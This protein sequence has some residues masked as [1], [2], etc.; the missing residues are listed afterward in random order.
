MNPLT[1]VVIGAGAGGLTAAAHLARRGMRVTVVE[2]NEEAGGRC[3]RVV[4]EGHTFDIGPTLY[5]MPKV[6]DHEFGALG[7][8]VHERL[9][10]QRVDST[11]HLVFDD[12]HRLELT[13]DR[14][15]MRMQL[16]AMEP[17][18]FAGFERYFRQGGCHYDLAM[19]H[20][21]GRNFR[22]LAEFINPASLRVFLQVGALTRHYAGMRSF[23]R[24]PHLKAAFT[25]QDMYMGLSPFEAPA[26][27]SMMQYTELAHGVWFPQ[28]GMYT[29]VQAVQA[30]A[31][32]NG[33]QLQFG[34]PVERILAREDRAT[35]IALADGRELPADIVVANADLPYVYR[36][37]LPQDGT[38][39]RLER[40]QYSCSTINFMW[41]TDRPYPQ[42]PAHVLF[43]SDDYRANFD[44]L[45]RDRTIASN[46]SVHIHA[47]TRLD[48]ALAPRGHDTL[49]AVVPVGH[50]N[51][52]HPQNWDH[53][54]A[55][56]REA[57]LQR[58]ARVGVTD[59]DAHLK[60]ELCF[61]P[62]DWQNRFNL[63]RGATHGLS[64]RLMQMGY[65][66]PHNRHARHRNLY[67]AGASTH[68]GTGLP[69]ALISGRLVAE[70]IAEDTG[71]G[72]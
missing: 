2:K 5:I 50:I 20:I 42:L 9:T 31:V 54:K 55:R 25:F 21:V 8:S 11:Y 61:T 24:S 63:V 34:T 56:A 16:E 29:V 15:R 68:P 70:R 32:Q 47:P 69:T 67:Y 26:T 62:P 1:V 40:R 57:L 36:E 27:F 6:F 13:S 10:L 52:A 41:A 45:Q 39:R 44:E 22:T 23:F 14:D 7:E 30:I 46:P 71:R 4:R 17:G 65:F 60:F 53:L 59:P 58:L 18:S 48:A 35:G 3:A 43:L 33:V 49:A 51:E 28:G 38:A 72:A 19:E 66:R 64:H 12:G 37:L